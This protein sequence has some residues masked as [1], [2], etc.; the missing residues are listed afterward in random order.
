MLIKWS[1]YVEGTRRGVTTNQF[2]SVDTQRET[3]KFNCKSSKSVKLFSGRKWPWSSWVAVNG[4]SNREQPWVAWF[5]KMSPCPQSRTTFNFET[6]TLMIAWLIWITN[7]C[8]SLVSRTLL[9]PRFDRFVREYKRNAHQKS[10]IYTRMYK[11]IYKLM[12]TYLRS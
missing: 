3:C 6:R 12:Y 7:T 10:Y 5:E 9:L 8:D 11:T 2:S 4:L 1:H